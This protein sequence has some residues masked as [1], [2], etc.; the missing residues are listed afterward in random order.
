[1]N[2]F[3]PPDDPDFDNPY[4]PPRSTFVPEAAPTIFGGIPFTVGDVFAWSW[5]IFKER[6]IPCIYLFW[7]VM[8]V[9]LAIGFATDKLLNG[10]LLV[11]REPA[12]LLFLRFI[13]NLTGV[14]VPLW[15]GIGMN[16]GLIK[17]ARHEPVSF[18][19]IFTGGRSVL[20]VFLGSILI[21][22]IVGAPLYVVAAGLVALFLT[23]QP[24]ESLT[25]LLLFVL[26]CGLAAVLLLYLVARL[27]QFYYLVIDRDLGV[28]E[29]IQ[30]SWQ[31]TTDRAATI[32][33]VY[34]LQICVFMAGLIACCVG[35]IFAW[36]LCAL[37][38]VVTYLALTGPAQT[39]LKAPP[40]TGDE[41]LFYPAEL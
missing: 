9:N 25:A 31:L 18:D 26:G 34:L 35:L 3:L 30:R 32:M 4:A 5:T 24:M 10:L 36:P 6:M 19:V 20:R 28:M 29:S 38:N 13:I 12:F 14:V 39:A 1:M 27:M 21:G 2:P 40:T 7:S 22:V 37:I 41:D 16:L 17:I 15:L 33:L 11:V 23:M 8:C